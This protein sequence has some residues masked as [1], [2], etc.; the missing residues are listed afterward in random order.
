MEFLERPGE[1]AV[2]PGMGRDWAPRQRR[3]TTTLMIARLLREGHPDVLCRVRNVSNGG[4]RIETPHALTQDERIGVELRTGQ[5][6]EGQVIWTAVGTAGMRFDAPVDV[7]AL[8]SQPL[9]R[10]AGPGAPMP[11]A[12]RF[13]AEAQVRLSFCGRI[14]SGVIENL[15]QS[16]ARMRIDDPE[17]VQGD[18]TASITGLEPRRAAIR[19][20]HE[21]EIGLIFLDKLKFVEFA[22][23]L[24]APAYRF[25]ARG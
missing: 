20:V 13:D 16:G 1:P 6:V 8:L 10:R 11:R 19:W 5:Q 18:V 25:S 12:P 21:D 3:T 23:W 22:R 24:G 15:S 4:M 14:R 2:L 17:L 9:D 7:D